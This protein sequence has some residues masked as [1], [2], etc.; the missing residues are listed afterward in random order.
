M[1]PP[2]I[3]RKEIKIMQRNAESI[4]HSLNDPFLRRHMRHPVIKKWKSSL[5]QLYKVSKEIQVKDVDKDI[6]KDLVPSDI[7]E[8]A[9]FLDKS[10]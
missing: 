3:D 8:F 10:P 7:R 2:K 4:L 9:P 1:K 5:A 6:L